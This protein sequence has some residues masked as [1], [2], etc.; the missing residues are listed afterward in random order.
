MP[1]RNRFAVL[2]N[3]LD[4]NR[5]ILDGVL[6][7]G[8]TVIDATCGNGHDSVYIAEKIGSAGALYCFDIQADAIKNTQEVL[9]KVA[10]KPKY[11]MLQESHEDLS[12]FVDSKV[13]CVFYNLGY[14]PNS[15]KLIT[16]TPEISIKS[17]QSAF[18]LLKPNGII[19]II[20]YLVHD[21]QKEYQQIKDFLLNLDQNEFSVAETTFML[22]KSSPVLFI[23]EKL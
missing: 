11:F 3:P 23:I 1:K 19:S 10:E 22:R 7:R 2:E 18:K 13:D 15:N 5:R 8:D 14:L 12:L 6:R 16:T 20:S 9:S 17:I 4:L 21:N